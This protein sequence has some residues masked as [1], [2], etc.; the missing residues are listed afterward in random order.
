MKNLLSNS[1]FPILLVGSLSMFFGEVISGASTTWFLNPEGILITYPLYLMHLLFLFAIGVKTGRV[2]I[3]HLYL[4]GMF[5]A[6]YESWITKVLWA[7][8][9]ESTSPGFGTFAGLAFPEFPI[10]VF[11]WHPVMSFILPILSLE[12]L[13]KKSISAHENLLKKSTTKSIVLGVFF[14]ILGTFIAKGNAYSLISSWLSLSGTLLIILV[15][16]SFSKKASILSIVP[17]KRGMLALLIYLIAI[18]TLTFFL[19]LPQRIPHSPLPYISILLT[20]FLVAILL[21][22][23]T[24]VSVTLTYLSGEYYGPLDFTIAMLLLFI[25]TSL[26]CIFP[27]IS[28]NVL[29]IA[30]FS[31]IFIGFSMLILAV[32][33]LLKY[34]RRYPQSL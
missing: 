23:S 27:K 13:T 24:R 4:L 29:I 8:Y 3:E 26:S 16:Y 30:Y 20:Y 31:L 19:L 15:L 1:I 32:K 28:E 7:G 11:F 22:K 6:L 9:M 17:G 33:N 25:S 21:W 18:Y 12:I 5:F 34:S 2:K 10:L 14:S